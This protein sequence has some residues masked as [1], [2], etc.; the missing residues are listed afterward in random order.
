VNVRIEETNVSPDF[1]RII[2]LSGKILH[3][4]KLDPG[5]SEFTMPINLRKGIYVLQMGEG[6][7]T[8]FSQKLVV[9]Q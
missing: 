4:E 1:I 8:L 2:S 9:N 5:I 3:E 7:V 6:K